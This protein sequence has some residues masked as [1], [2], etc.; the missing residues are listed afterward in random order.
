M[1]VEFSL[2]FT[3]KVQVLPKAT[4]GMEQKLLIMQQRR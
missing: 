2:V 3:D 1:A 4:L